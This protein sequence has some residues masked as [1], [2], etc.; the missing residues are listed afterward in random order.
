MSKN[1]IMAMAP[2]ICSPTQSVAPTDQSDESLIVQKN[3]VQYK[4]TGTPKAPKKLE[5]PLSTTARTKCATGATP[6]SKASMKKSKEA[7]TPPRTTNTP[8]SVVQSL[9]EAA[10]ISFPILINGESP[11]RPTQTLVKLEKLPI[12]NTVTVRNTKTFKKDTKKMSREEGWVGT[13]RGEI[14]EKPCSQCSRGH[15]PFT[16]CCVVEGMQHAAPVTQTNG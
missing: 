12:L 5:T 13:E 4:K 9:S 8:A 15:N 3:S 10:L 7:K 16:L 11:S 2:K 1:A 6:K 14:A